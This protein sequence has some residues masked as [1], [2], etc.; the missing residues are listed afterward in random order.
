MRM[1]LHT[2]FSMYPIRV[3]TNRNLE[4]KKNT[5]VSYAWWYSPIATASKGWGRKITSLRPTEHILEFL[6]QHTEANS[7]QTRQWRCD[8]GQ[9]SGLACRGSWV[10]SLAPGEKQHLLCYCCLIFIIIIIKV[11]LFYL[12]EY[13]AACTYVNHVHAWCLWS[14]KRVMGP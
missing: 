7:K 13:S 6:Q 3:K 10:L 9:S 1:Q 8:S 12:Y 11:L 14:P 2:T 4:G 5:F